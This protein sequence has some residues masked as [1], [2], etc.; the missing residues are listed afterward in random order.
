V[1]VFRMGYLQVAIVVVLILLLDV[2][3]AGSE[4]VVLALLR[5][6][7][8]QGRSLGVAVLGGGGR[9]GRPGGVGEHGRY[10]NTLLI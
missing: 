4:G 10:D 6:G 5:W 8:I 3:L 9:G 1:G 2:S 7:V